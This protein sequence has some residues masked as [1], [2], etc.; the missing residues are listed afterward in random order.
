MNSQPGTDASPAAAPNRFV[1]HPRYRG[2]LVEEVRVEVAQELARDQR[3]YALVLEG[4]EQQ[5]NAALASVLDLEKKWGPFDF[6]WAET[7]ADDLAAR[8]TAFEKARDDRQELF[9]YERYRDEVL[10]PR[11]PRPR[12]GSAS[13]NRPGLPVGGRLPLRWLVIAAVV[14]VLLLLLLLG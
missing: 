10:A 5:E 14:A 8:I 3:A 2:R 7:D 9:P 11:M 4:A 1:W 13:S 6:G 12:G